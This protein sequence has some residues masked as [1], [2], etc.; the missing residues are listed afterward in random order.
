MKLSVLM[1]VYAKE[2]PAYLRECMESLAAQTHPADELV[3]VEDGPIG[4]ELCHMIEH[5]RERLS[6]RSVRLP[7]NAGL[8]EALR[9]GLAAC[10]SEFVARMDSDDI[11]ASERFER[12]L[13]FLEEHP[14]VDVVGSAIAE[15]DTDWMAPHSVRRLPAGGEE[16]LRIARMRTPLNHQTVMFRREPVMAVG[17][18]QSCHGF[19]DYHLWAR[20][21]VAGAQLHNLPEPMVFARCGNG[22]QGRRGGWSYMRREIGAH[23][24][25]R[26]IGL[27]TILD[28]L[29]NIFARSPLR[30]A[31][32]CFRAFFYRAFLRTRYVPPRW[33]A[34]TGRH[35]IASGALPTAWGVSPTVE[36]GNRPLVSIITP[37]YNA[38]RWLS[39]TLESVAAQ[40]FEDW[41]HILVD[42][43]STDDSC[44]LLEAA[45]ARDPRIRLLR[46]RR[47][48]GSPQARN[49]ALDAARGR[50]I[51][52]LDADDLW[53]P[54]KLSR[55]LGW[56]Q[57]HGHE[58][59]YHDYRHISHDGR[60]VGA[61]VKGPEELNMRSLHTR[62][63]T[64]CLTV[65]L[66]RNKI[67]K[68]RFPNLK[69]PY[70]AE[71]FCLWLSLIQRGYVGHRLP[72]DLARY[73][74]SKDSRSANKLKGA[75]NA[76]RLYRN[77]SRLSFLHAALWWIQYAWNDFWLYQYARPR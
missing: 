55:S 4:E 8:G 36:S 59:I 70:R 9:I 17:S 11:C 49:L 33:I 23:F 66:D 46:M 27:I 7:A 62:R 3:L 65:V 52:F 37:V 54:E 57:E 47:N 60:Q 26:R 74:L 71:D 25:L 28:C 67:A 18:Y 69:R 41:E 20:M 34:Q 10:R 32:S 30:L 51:A 5:F 19:E 75:L 40:T 24:L 39:E 76:W 1:S 44:G 12:Q 43:G 50:Y 15:F 42:D 38:G 21:L 77:F 31:P 61:L 48:I 13:Q 63:G 58:F 29:R 45:A 72:L 56:M 73:R 6:I 22:M 53:H 64:G 14:E 2:S 35:W 16:L 68:F